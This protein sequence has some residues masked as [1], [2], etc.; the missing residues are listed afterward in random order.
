[1]Q[2]VV[3]SEIPFN[4]TLNSNSKERFLELDIKFILNEKIIKR[5]GWNN[6]GVGQG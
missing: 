2:Y 6:K 3:K 1:M 5:E 4:L